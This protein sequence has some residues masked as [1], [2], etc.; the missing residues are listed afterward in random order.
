[1][2]FSAALSKHPAAITRINVSSSLISAGVY[3]SRN[4]IH[5][6]KKEKVLDGIQYRQ[7]PLSPPLPIYLS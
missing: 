1:M 6:N 3:A 5:V 4:I 2:R 7:K